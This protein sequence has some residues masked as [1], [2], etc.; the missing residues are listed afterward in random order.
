MGNEVGGAASRCTSAPGGHHAAHIDTTG[1]VY[2]ARAEQVDS[3]VPLGVVLD[4]GRRVCL[5]RDGASIHAVEDRCPHRD[6]A[7][8]GGDLV[9]PGVL[10]CPWHGARF[11]VRSG[12]ALQGP[13]TDALAVFEVC[14]TAG[15]VLVGPRRS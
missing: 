9:S 8:S 14:V 7:L 15:L 10:E 11:D 5:V 1:F 13:A 12:A 3:A 4:D 2:A 6:Y